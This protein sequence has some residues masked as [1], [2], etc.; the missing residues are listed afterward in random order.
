MTTSGCV[1][2]ADCC[3]GRVR[4]A[5]I[6]VPSRLGKGSDS[7]GVICRCASRAALSDVRR[8]GAAVPVF[9]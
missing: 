2:V 9:V 6:A 8:I 4:N 3:N 1:D 7:T 5:S